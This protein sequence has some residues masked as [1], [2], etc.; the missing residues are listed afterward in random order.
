[1][2]VDLVVHIN[3]GPQHGTSHFEEH[4]SFLRVE[5]AFPSGLK[6]IHSNPKR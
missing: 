6:L 1:M 5:N 2:D 3:R 4:P